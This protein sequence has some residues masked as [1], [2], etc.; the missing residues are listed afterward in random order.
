MR[1][2]DASKFRG[3]PQNYVAELSATTEELE[4]LWGP[5]EITW[6]DLGPWFTF[7]FALNDGILAA[8]V[9]E[10]ENAPNPGYILTAIGESPL[11]EILE[12]FLRESGFDAG[13]VQRRGFE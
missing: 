4:G 12:A 2:I 13:R 5:N 10:V 6:D 3:K 9:R 8:L 1:R 11:A 7:A